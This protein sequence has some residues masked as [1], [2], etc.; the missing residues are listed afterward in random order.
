MVP[1]SHA[2]GIVGLMNSDY[3]LCYN[4]AACETEGLTA[5]SHFEVK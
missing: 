5:T 2:G 4:S 1:P 3:A